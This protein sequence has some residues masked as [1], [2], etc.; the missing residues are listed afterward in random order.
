[1]GI[2][3]SMF[4]SGYLAIYYGWPSIFYVFGLYFTFVYNLND[5]PTVAY[6]LGLSIPRSQC[7]PGR[8]VRA[9]ASDTSTK[10]IDREGLGKR[11]AG[12]TRQH[13]T[14]HFAS[15]DQSLLLSSS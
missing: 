15:H 2:I 10:C 7:L 9:F 8:V 13:L 1:M 3:V 11:R 14:V 5:V 4:C 6:L 12:L